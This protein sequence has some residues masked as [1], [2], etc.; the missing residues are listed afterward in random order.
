MIKNT[1][2]IEGQAPG[3]QTQTLSTANSGVKGLSEQIHKAPS[4][5]SGSLLDEG[6]V[7]ASLSLT[8]DC[9]KLFIWLNPFLA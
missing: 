3:T 9:F 6:R 7:M 8:Q 1:S 4:S 2:S 5:C